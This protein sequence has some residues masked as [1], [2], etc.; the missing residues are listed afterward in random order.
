MSEKTPNE[1]HL[2]FFTNKGTKIKEGFHELS[3][4]PNKIFAIQDTT[5]DHKDRF[6][7]HI[8]FHIRLP[9][10][11]GD[12]YAHFSLYLTK[13]DAKRLKNQIV[14]DKGESKY[15]YRRRNPEKNRA[16]VYAI[17][18]VPLKDH[19]ERC[20]VKGV[21]LVRHHADYSKPLE[22]ETLC[23]KCHK[24]ADA[25]RKDKNVSMKNRHCSTCGKIIDECERIRP[26]FK[27]RPC[28]FWIPKDLS[29]GQK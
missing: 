3:Q 20:G 2:F 16:Q 21:K 25:E 11:F 19:C 5:S 27:G 23:L 10:M 1:S 26:S 18:N 9:K 17:R 14:V 12:D 22:V 6:P 24:I 28:T 7:I 15:A 8:Q 4:I 13:D 29:G